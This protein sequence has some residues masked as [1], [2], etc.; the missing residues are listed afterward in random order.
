MSSNPSKEKKAAEQNFSK[1]TKDQIELM[2]QMPEMYNKMTEAWLNFAA[3]N[4]V[5]D[6]KAQQVF[7]QF[8]ESLSNAY[9]DYMEKFCKPF[10][11]RGL[12]F[13]ITDKGYA[14]DI[15]NAWKSWL[16]SPEKG[17]DKAREGM[18][19]FS[20][21]TLEMSDK[22]REGYEKLTRSQF[23]FMQNI[24]QASKSGEPGQVMKAFSES[25]KNLLEAY[26]SFC[27]EETNRCFE[28]FKSLAPRI[29]ANV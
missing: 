28:L 4:P 5:K 27:S 14:A 7:G 29:R 6:D 2:A 18:K 24:L 19:E 25:S 9:T 21:I 12:P 22:I 26:Y 3:I 8:T 15:V 10:F 23:E 11:A 16:D 13:P 20:R 17:I 1:S